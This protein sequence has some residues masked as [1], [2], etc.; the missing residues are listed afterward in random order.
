MTVTT[1]AVVREAAR[2]RSTGGAFRGSRRRLSA[3]ALAALAA[4]AAACGDEAPSPTVGSTVTVAAAPTKTQAGEGRVDVAA[5]GPWLDPAITGPFEAATGCT[6]NRVAAG[7]SADVIEA[8]GDRTAALVARGVV[9]PIDDD[10]LPTLSD[11]PARL[12]DATPTRVDGRRYGVPYAWGANELA[13]RPGVLPEGGRASWEALYDPAHRGRIVTPDGADGLAAAALLLRVADPYGLDEGRLRA[14]AALLREQRPLLLMRW[15]SPAEAMRLFSEGR[16]AVGMLPTRLVLELRAQN[17]PVASVQPVEG[18][19]GWLRQWH[20]GRHAAHPVC[21]YRWIDQAL[22]PAAQARL[23]ELG[24][25]APVNPDACVL[26]GASR[27]ADLHVPD[28]SYLA[29]VHFAHAP[30]DPGAWAAAWTSVV[31]GRG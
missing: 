8:G 5:A 22:Q 20:L 28:A 6:V 29:G 30:P 27:C 13:Y 31:R 21:A 1:P 2:L 4:L 9:Q 11:V 3:L 23:V 19:T 25:D 14:A 17:V 12:R 16:A 18:A 10:G 24:G 15:R 26:V 7:A